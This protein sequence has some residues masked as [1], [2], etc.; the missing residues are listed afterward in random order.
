[1]IRLLKLGGAERV[2]DA[3]HELFPDAPVFTLVFDPKF[4]EKYK[5]WDI[6][7][8]GLQTLFLSIG[9]LQYLLP[10]IPWGVDNLDFND[11]DLVISSSSG[12]VKNIRVPKNCIHINY[13]H[14]PTRFL[15]SEPDYV[16]QEVPALIRPLVKLFLGHMKK[17]DY[18]GAQRVTKFIANS[19][20]V[21]GRIKKY[22]NRDSDN[23]LSVYRHQFLASNLQ[24]RHC[25]ECIRRS[26]SIKE[27]IAASA[28]QGPGLTSNDDKSKTI[29][30]LPAA[31]RPTR[32]MIL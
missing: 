10:L 6:R 13:C 29:F 9:K 4:R 27:E 16:N 1:M 26:N 17:W 24:P 12:F 32:R 18:K 5:N 3:L 28:S 21:Q 14:T 7:T 22:Y 23:Y 8:S 25:E 2:V 31:C 11:F 20:E 15:W 19:K 30:S